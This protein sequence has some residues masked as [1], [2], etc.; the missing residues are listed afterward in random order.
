MLAPPREGRG[1]EGCRITDALD[2]LLFVDPV[3]TGMPDGVAA[4]GLARALLGSPGAAV[5][6]LDETGLPMCGGRSWAAWYGRRW[7]GAR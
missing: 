6:D 7:S 5:V 2:A 1:G 4:G 3:E